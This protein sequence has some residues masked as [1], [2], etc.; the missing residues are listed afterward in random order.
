MAT[1]GSLTTLVN[2]LSPLVG[3]NNLILDIQAGNAVKGLGEKTFATVDFDT[4]H[5]LLTVVSMVIFFL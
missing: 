3:T 1:T 2:E 5:P 4:N